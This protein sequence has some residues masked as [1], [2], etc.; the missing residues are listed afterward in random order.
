MQQT[1]IFL[2]IEYCFHNVGFL[3]NTIP[4][5]LSSSFC[6]PKNVNLDKMHDFKR[7]SMM[8]FASI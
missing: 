7:Q 6:Y 3:K 5:I 1:N 4:S 2:K 8:L